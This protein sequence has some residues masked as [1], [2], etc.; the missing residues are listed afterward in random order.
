MKLTLDGS[1]PPPSMQLDIS[2][3][4]ID[5]CAYDDTLQNTA[6]LFSGRQ[7]SA[8]LAA[9]TMNNEQS[10]VVVVSVRNYD[11]GLGVQ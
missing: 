3:Y 6:T 8:L 1:S 10:A 7:R 4:E 11:D 5:L 9:T 2:R